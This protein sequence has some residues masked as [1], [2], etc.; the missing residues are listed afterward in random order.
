[1]EIRLLRPDDDRSHFDSGDTRLDGFLRQFAGQNQFRLHL[2]S[3][4]VAVEGKR[5]LGFA[6]IAPGNIEIARL[7][8]AQRRGL[9][10]YPIPILRVARL[11]TALSERGKGVG[12][13]LLRC[14][15]TLALKL[16]EEYGCIG[17]VV[18][19]KPGAQAYYEKFGFLEI[20]CV[21]GT[22]AARPEPVEMFLP[23]ELVRKASAS[24]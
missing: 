8:A 18:D 24:E 21:A 16:S 7:P 4:W 1:M 10:R 5:N 14:T 6:T 20:G 19:A 11:A 23:L 9:P 17:V 2:G 15:F 22:G 12:N 13:A 3:T